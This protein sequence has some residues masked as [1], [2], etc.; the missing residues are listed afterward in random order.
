MVTKKIYSNKVLLYVQK[1]FE[2]NV[3]CFIL[4]ILKYNV[5]KVSQILNHLT[6]F[7]IQVIFCLDSW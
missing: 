2:K 7:L 1:V 6:D 3:D 4:T 5:Q